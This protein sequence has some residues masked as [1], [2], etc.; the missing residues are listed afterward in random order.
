MQP[1]AS[2]AAQPMDVDDE[3]PN[4]DSQPSVT[5]PVPEQQLHPPVQEPTRVTDVAP[6]TSMEL[7]PSSLV[8]HPRVQRLGRQPV[9]VLPAPEENR[10]VSVMTDPVT[11]NNQLVLRPENAV[12]VGENRRDNDN[13]RV[14]R[15]PRLMPPP[16]RANVVSEVPTSYQSTMQSANSEDGT[17]P[18]VVSLCHRVSMMYRSL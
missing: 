7:A 11:D 12:V 6:E 13:Y 3:G 2:G 15:R 16:E 1:I 10:P 14:P 4:L 5:P 17:K 8:F 18:F 9:A